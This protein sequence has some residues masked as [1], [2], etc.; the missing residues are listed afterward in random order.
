MALDLAGKQAIVA[1]VAKLVATAEAIVLAEYRG[2]EVGK[3]T[4]LRAQARKSGVHLRVLRNTLAR[5]AV[6]E[7][8]FQGLSD[9]MA[10]PLLYGIS[11]DP[12]A[13]AR[14]LNDFA[15]ANDKLVV[16]AGAMRNQVMSA[17]DVA[18]LANLPSRNELLARLLGTMQAPV[19]TFVRTL[20]DVPGKFVRALAA[21]HDQKQTA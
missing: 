16:K 19:A 15:K 2:L 7:T 20:N 17:K 14:V 12:V 10:G 9:Q 21:I 8:P 6:A 11:E 5:R 18:A 3:M 4:A 1:D 13:L